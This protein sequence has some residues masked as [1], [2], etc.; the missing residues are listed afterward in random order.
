MSANAPTARQLA[1]VAAVLGLYLSVASL[2]AY[3]CTCVLAESPCTTLT[4]ADA[5]FEGVVESSTKAEPL[6]MPAVAGRPVSIQQ[7]TVVF[8]D[9]QRYL[10]VPASSVTTNAQESSCGVEFEPGA[11]YLVVA[12][13]RVSDGVLV[14]SRCSQTRKLQPADPWR[15]YARSLATGEKGGRI[16]GTVSLSGWQP[17]AGARVTVQGRR[18]FSVVTAEDG[19]YLIAG[20]PE[21]RYR[22]SVQTPA[23]LAPAR[24]GAPM[25]AILDRETR[26]AEVPLSISPDTRITGVVTNPTTKGP[27]RTVVELWSQPD[28]QTTPR[29]MISHQVDVNGGYT[30]SDPVPGRYFVGVNVGARPTLVFPYFEEIAETAGGVRFFDVSLGGRIAMSPLTLQPVAGTEISGKV[31]QR[32]GSAAKGVTV[33]LLGFGAAPEV[34]YATSKDD[35]GFTFRALRGERYR[36]AAYVNRQLVIEVEA[37][38]DTG[39]VMLTLPD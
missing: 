12:Q 9:V 16:W 2:P 23:T 10:G 8:R 18:D 3:A 31:L 29:K 30:F 38:A 22:V 21:G 36:F 6:S 24:A 5:L 4:Q 7:R 14:V 17:V 37:A 34:T 28:P 13:R 27:L 11:R 19:R 20:L 25:P 33:R 15:D 39:T 1:F 35:G 26:C 32:H